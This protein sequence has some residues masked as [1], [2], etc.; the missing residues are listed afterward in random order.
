MSPILTLDAGELADEP[1]ALL[2][3]PHRLHVACGG[4][5]GDAASMARTLEVARRHGVEI[6]AHPSYEDRA[7]FG[8]T[9]VNVSPDVLGA[10]VQAQCAAIAAIARQ[11]GMR[12]RSVKMH[13][14]LY[15]DV[16]SDRQ[17]AG[18]VLQ[19]AIS[20][21]GP[22]AVV[23]QEGAL[24][25][26]ARARGLTVLREGFA[27]RAMRPDGRLVPRSEPGA[28]LDD[29]AAAAA[30][31]RRLVASGAIDAICVHGDGP[32]ALAIA[33]AVRRTLAS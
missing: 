30:Q 33:R 1:E 7:G 28:L 32:N 4:H 18:A 15:H 27:D 8:R 19:A 11:A 24:A 2:A 29:P 16:L 31:A 20:A 13:G 9:S 22:V 12:L 23:T 21:L 17:R 5:A 6:G 26:L 14:A 3:A 25:E 10:Q